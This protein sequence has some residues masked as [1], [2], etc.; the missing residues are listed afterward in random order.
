MFLLF[1]FYFHLYSSISFTF[2]LQILFDLV[3]LLLFYLVFV[4]LYL[5]LFLSLRKLLSQKCSVKANS[6]ILFFSRHI[7]EHV[8]IFCFFR[9]LFVKETCFKLYLTS[10]LIC[11]LC[12][13]IYIRAHN[14][15][16]TL[17]RCLF[18]PSLLR[19]TLNLARN[20]ACFILETLC[21]LQWCL[22]VFSAFTEF[23]IINF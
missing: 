18:W 7:W 9:L 13:I 1:S 16:A 10:A 5:S 11:Y 6:F 14:I 21:S 22:G 2:A 19:V 23:C 4:L 3:L 20:E 8:L 17:W 12:F 15:F